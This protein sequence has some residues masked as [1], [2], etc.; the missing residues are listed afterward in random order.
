M[1]D[2]NLE[3]KLFNGLLILGGLVFSFLVVY[4]VIIS[5]GN[6][7][8]NTYKFLL[9]VSFLLGLFAPRASFYLIV[10]C[11]AYIDLFKRFMVFDFGL[12]HF[13]LY[14]ILGIPPMIAV[15]IFISIITTYLLRWRKAEKG[16]FLLLFGTIIACVVLSA[17]TYFVDKLGLQ[18]IVYSSALPTIF[19]TF[20]I[21]FKT[22]SEILRFIFFTCLIFI[23]VAL[24]G[25]KQSYFGLSDF[26][27]RYTY[28][29][30]TRHTEVFWDLV[31]R[32]YSTMASEGQL[33]YAMSFC[34]VLTF[35]LA[36][37]KVYQRKALSF[38]LIPYIALFVLFVV[39]GIYSLN[40]LNVL[41][42]IITI[43]SFCFLGTKLKTGILYFLATIAFL[44]MVFFGREVIN[45]F[46]SLVSKRI[47]N[48]SAT[49]HLLLR[50]STF[51]TRLNTLQMLKDPS[52]YSLMGV[53]RHLRTEQQNRTHAW[54]SKYIL[55]YG[56][57]A[58]FA[59]L[60]S[61]AFVFYKIHS[62]A[63]RSPPGEWKILYLIFSSNAFASIAISM[64]GNNALNSFP[65]NF[66]LYLSFAILISLVLKDPDRPS[67]KKTQPP[68]ERQIE[69][70]T[71]P[72]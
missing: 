11:A 20:P 21:L 53:P 28:S 58:F 13:D 14:F 62:F 16:D 15:G 49:T 1:A 48:K 66:F 43:I 55:D 57:I 25:L 54:Y 6:V 47:E 38:F 5:P 64:L 52:T 23:P 2:S 17:L 32:P 36:A 24:Y 9:P 60:G 67:A 22:R 45:T 19:F 27:I 69:M 72:A 30:L 12:Q 8:G 65:S 63:W 18:Y 70:S 68:V 26:E 44:S 46:N 56:A 40:R 34:A 42:W 31:A 61:I 10:F 59:V 7:L 29:G 71:L 41:L 51:Q 39:A 35:A 37:R 50:T 4:L 33:S 3:N